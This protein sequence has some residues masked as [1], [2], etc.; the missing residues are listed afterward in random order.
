[1]NF[2]G[3]RFLSSSLLIFGFRIRRRILDLWTFVLSL[4]L[5]R[6]ERMER[7]RLG[8]G[9]DGSA[10]DSVQYRYHQPKPMKS[11]SSHTRHFL[12]SCSCLLSCMPMLIFSFASIYGLGLVMASSCI[13]EYSLVVSHVQALMQNKSR[14]TGGTCIYIVIEADCTCTAIYKQPEQ[15]VH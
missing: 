1:M 4:L 5:G 12:K 11:R 9:M 2:V 7:L 10:G 15:R 14:L 3:Y 8:N 13:S 6:L